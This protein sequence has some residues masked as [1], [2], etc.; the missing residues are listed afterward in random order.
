MVDRA[1]CA[2]K[3][4]TT[5]T[6]TAQHHAMHASLVAFTGARP[7]VSRSSAFGHTCIIVHL[8]LVH[9]QG[10]VHVSGHACRRSS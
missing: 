10:G 4:R 9:V 7:T 2:S 1:G 5:L 8:A 3:A 6:R